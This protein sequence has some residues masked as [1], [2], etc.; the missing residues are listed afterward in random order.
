MSR[1]VAGGAG[2]RAGR[3]LRA[4]SGC[5]FAA[6]LLPLMALAGTRGDYAR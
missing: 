2:N 3:A 6:L 1:Q 4:G 5:L